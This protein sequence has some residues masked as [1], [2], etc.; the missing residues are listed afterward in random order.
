ML[1]KELFLCSVSTSTTEK[2][3]KLCPQPRHRDCP[4]PVPGPVLPGLY[5]PPP[6]GYDCKGRGAELM[7]MNRR[8]DTCRE[9][10]EKLR[11]GLSWEMGEKFYLRKWLL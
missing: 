1:E 8:K 4:G 5:I 2:E 9:D 3:A 10:G 6:V 7:V 11:L